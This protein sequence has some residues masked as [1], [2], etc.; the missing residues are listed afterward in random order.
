ME[1]FSALLALYEGNSPVTGEFPSQKPVTRIL[2]FSFLCLNKRLSK[3]STRRWLEAPLRSSWRHWKD[4]GRYKYKL[5]CR[6]HFH[7]MTSSWL[8]IVKI[9][10]ITRFGEYYS[11]IMPMAQKHAMCLIVYN[12]DHPTSL[13]S[14]DR[15]QTIGALKFSTL[16]ENRIFQCMCKIV[17]VQ[18]QRWPKVS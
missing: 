15:I 18:F 2:V 12:N 7:L 13:F 11:K 16:Y 5:F 6:R 17:C 3:P 4:W 14:V 10:K 8:H 1:A 9:C